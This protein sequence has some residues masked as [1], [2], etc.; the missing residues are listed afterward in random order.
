[1]LKVVLY[2][3]FL[4]ITGIAA[5]IMFMNY[6]L[7]KMFYIP[8]VKSQKTPADFNL[9]HKEFFV[10]SK[11]HKRIQVWDIN[12][13]N[14][15]LVTL[16]VHGWANTSD[17]FLP[18]AAELSD[19]RRMLL[20]NT[21][22]HGG[23][24]DEKYMTLL[25]YA[26]DINTVIDHLEENSDKPIQV[27]LI[28]HSLGGAAVLWHASK[29]TRVKSVT[30]IG[31]FADLENVMRTGFAQNTLFRGFVG[32]LF[33]FVEFRIGEKMETI[34]PQNS[35]SLYKGPILLTHGTKDTVVDF[36]DLNKIRKAA[37]RENVEQFIMKG[38]GHSDL[39]VNKELADR[40]DQ[41]ISKHE[42]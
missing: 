15:G 33:A 16:A 41:F 5:I 29:D 36:T 24:D 38:F 18:M 19:R 7:N 35:V 20:L 14:D 27:H 6:I 37:H 4:S 22:S 10:N 39:L 8:H 26:E 11:H 12:P 23:S 31:T 42:T 25:K 17:S 32:S 13:E 34:S 1:M 2:I 28:G 3:I 40:I 21:R 9:E 30:T